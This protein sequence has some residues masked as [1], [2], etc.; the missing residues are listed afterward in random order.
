MGLS[1]ATKSGR[2]LKPCS[3]LPIVAGNEPPPCAK[4]T[5]SLGNFSNI[6]PKIIEQ[7]ANDD[8]AGIPTNQGNQYFCI[9]S[10]DIISQ[11]CTKIAAPNFSASS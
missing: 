3:I 8:S 1:I 2:T 5:R 9:F 11:G 10:F 7:I 4:A 6:P